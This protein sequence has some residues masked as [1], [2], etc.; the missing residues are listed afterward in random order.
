MLRLNRIKRQPHGVRALCARMLITF[1]RTWKRKQ[2]ESRHRWRP[3]SVMEFIHYGWWFILCSIKE[4]IYFQKGH[5]RGNR[6]SRAIEMVANRYSPNQEEGKGVLVTEDWERKTK[7]FSCIWRFLLL[8][9]VTGA[10]S[11][12]FEPIIK[13]HKFFRIVYLFS[14]KSSTMNRLPVLPV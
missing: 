6:H 7:F 2:I 1:C 11:C 9:W 5:P 10:C 3:I 13:Q 8:Q 14:E 4:G 12:V